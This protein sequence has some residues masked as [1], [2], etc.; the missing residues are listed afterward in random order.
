MSST[1]MS[2]NSVSTVYALRAKTVDIRWAHHSHHDVYFIMMVF[3][4][5][6]RQK[7]RAV[8]KDKGKPACRLTSCRHNALIHKTTTKMSHTTLLSELLSPPPSLYRI[9]CAQPHLS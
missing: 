9:D 6:F 3:L 7:T 2:V 5:E 4:H 1:T 8:L